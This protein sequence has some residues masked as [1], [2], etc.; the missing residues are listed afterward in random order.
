MVLTVQPQTVK[1]TNDSI[2][3]ITASPADLLKA[4]SYEFAADSAS[5]SDD[6]EDAVFE[7]KDLSDADLE[8]LKR[9]YEKSRRVQ[10]VDEKL[11]SMPELAL[12]D[13]ESL[14]L[15]AGEKPILLRQKSVGEQVNFVARLTS[16]FGALSDIGCLG[17]A[18]L[19]QE[20]SPVPTLTRQARL[21]RIESSILDALSDISSL[22]NVEESKRQES[23]VF[24]KLQALDGFDFDGSSA[25]SVPESERQ[26]PNVLQNIKL[27]NGFDFDGSAPCD[28]VSLPRQ[29]CMYN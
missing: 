3:E 10:A 16:A 9:A 19:G 25:A 5:S 26:K 15:A 4:L 22:S 29:G 2:H 11:R 23:D 14:T 20:N 6:G 8:Q 28:Q 17:G 21:I 18:E 7:Y 1:S 27:L 24:Q 12:H 13:R